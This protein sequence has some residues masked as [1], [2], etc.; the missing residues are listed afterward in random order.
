MF[1]SFGGQKVLHMDKSDEFDWRQA[2]WTLFYIAVIWP[3]SWLM[4]YYRMLIWFI[5][6][7]T[8]FDWLGRFS[9]GWGILYTHDTTNREF[10]KMERQI[11]RLQ[12]RMATLD[13]PTN[14]REYQLYKAIAQKYDWPYIVQLHDNSQA[15]APTLTPHSATPI[16]PLP[17][18]IAHLKAAWLTLGWVISAAAVVNLWINDVPLFSQPV[19]AIFAAIFLVLAI[20]LLFYS[21][22]LITRLLRRTF[23]FIR[24]HIQ[25]SS[26]KTD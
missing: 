6:E 23:N 19:E 22:I 21:L 9:P 25:P 2:A 8:G 12:H 5:I 16:M 20:Q 17:L 24:R 15:S 4:H 7:H 10:Y 14:R 3:F 11:Y 18:V 26:S 13:V 1:A